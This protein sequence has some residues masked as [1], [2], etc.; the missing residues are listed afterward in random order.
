MFSCKFSKIVK[1]IFFIEH[2]WVLQ[3]AVEHRKISTHFQN[4]QFL[5]FLK[6][7]LQFLLI[8]FEF[9]L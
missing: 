4:K 2:L 9:G 5:Q 3:N 7:F 6:F 1:N 8:T